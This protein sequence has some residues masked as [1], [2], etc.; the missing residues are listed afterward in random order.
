[1]ELFEITHTSS[2]NGNSYTASL[3]WEEAELINGEVSFQLTIFQTQRGEK[4]TEFSCSVALAYDPE[5]QEPQL[6]VSSNEVELFT[7]SLDGLY[8]KQ[9]IVERII[10]AIPAVDPVVGCLARA[11]LSV[12][13]GQIISCVRQNRHKIWR[14]GLAATAACVRDHIPTMCLRFAVRTAKCMLKGGF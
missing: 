2:R 9:E 12:T 5:T 6:L 3:E 11:G 4:R 14:E 7:V 8:S 13:V 1:M 10:E